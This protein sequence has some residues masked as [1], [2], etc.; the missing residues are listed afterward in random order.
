MKYEDECMTSTTPRTP[1]YRS[2]KPMPPCRE[3]R[4]T[5]NSITDLINSNGELLCN[6]Y[7]LTK[8]IGAHLANVREDEPMEDFNTKNVDIYTLL[9][10]Q[11]D[12][13]KRVSGLLGSI[14][15]VL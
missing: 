8:E 2:N 11:N 12:I 14:N 6:C 3:A 1:M 5:M 15:A 4:E 7:N 13:L 10:L 9:E